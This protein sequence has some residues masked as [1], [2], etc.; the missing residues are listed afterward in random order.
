[1]IELFTDLVF[2][3][4]ISWYFLSILPT[5]TKGKLGWYILVSKKLAGAPFPIQKGGL[6][7]PSGALSLPFEGKRVSCRLKKKSSQKLQKRVPA[8]SY[9]TKEQNN[10]R[11]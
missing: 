8:K 3:V 6:W 2:L 11:N 10:L 7:T 1:M 5:D 4:G 9:S